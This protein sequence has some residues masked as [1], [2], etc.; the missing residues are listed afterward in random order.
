LNL[1]NRNCKRKTITQIK[2]SNGLYATKD[3]DTLKECNSFYSR[4]YISKKP[5]VTSLSDNMFFGQEHATLGDIDKQIC[6]GPLSAKE[7]LEALKQWN[8][9]NRLE[10]TAF[11][12]NSIKYF[13]RMS[14]LFLCVI[15]KCP[16][17][18]KNHFL[19][20]LGF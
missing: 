14:L 16:C 6:E 11:L 9:V 8:P 7:C 17:D 20:F 2:T 12:P 1:E 3:P 15:L 13:G 4:L 5:A 18:K 19:F 10:Q